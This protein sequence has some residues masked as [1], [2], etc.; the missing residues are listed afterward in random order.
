MML[1]MTITAISSTMVKPWDARRA[2]A[3]LSNPW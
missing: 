1:V 2:M 3:E